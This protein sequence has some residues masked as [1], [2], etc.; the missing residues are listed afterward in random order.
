MTNSRSSGAGARSMG[1]GEVLYEL[2]RPDY[3]AEARPT[4]L[5]CRHGVHT[6]RGAPG[7]G[8]RRCCRGESAPDGRSAPRLDP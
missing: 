6:A 7:R 2:I 8:A 3:G 1:S 4:A 5:A